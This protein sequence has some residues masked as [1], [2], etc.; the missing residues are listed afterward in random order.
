M[1]CH[2]VTI[3]RFREIQTS[4][5]MKENDISEIPTAFQYSEID[6]LNLEDLCYAGSPDFECQHCQAKLWEEESKGFCCP[7][8]KVEI[9]ELPNPP[10]VLKQLLSG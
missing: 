6:S 4:E 1:L 7:K 3:L 2:H 5:K 8:R 9:E 10:S